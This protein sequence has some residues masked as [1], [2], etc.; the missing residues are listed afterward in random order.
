MNEKQELLR[1]AVPALL[2]RLV[3]PRCVDADGAPTG[4]DAGA[5]GTCPAGQEPE[6]APVRD[7]HLA[8]VTSSLGAHGG[9]VCDATFEPSEDDRGMPIGRVRSGLRAAARRWH[10]SPAR[11]TTPAGRA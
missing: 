7:I 6:F 3:T 5:D 9:Q 10:G 4:V 2:R 11:S 8:V 1:D